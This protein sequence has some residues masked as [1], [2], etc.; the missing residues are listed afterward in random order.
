M[1]AGIRGR[2]TY[3]N[4]TAT[5]ALFIAL[6]AGAYA[7]GLARDSVRSK[8]IKDG[9]VKEADLG[10]DAVTATKL[11]DD[12]VGSPNVI[13]DALQGG[14]ISESSLFN[15]NSLDGADLDES[16]LF[17]DNS[18]Q[19][20]DIDETTLSGVNAAK[21]GGGDVCR[22][23]GTYTLTATDIENVC[24]AGP[25]TLEASCF[26]VGST[27]VASLDLLT[28][29]D[30]AYVGRSS[31]T[32]FTDPDFDTNESPA[33]TQVVDDVGG[34]GST[35]FAASFFAGL[36]GSGQLVG[37]AGVHATAT[38]PG[39]DTCHFNVVAFG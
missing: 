22:S 30:N 21:V 11:G 31:N 20:A 19:G 24:T 27:V 33:M 35:W 39:I 32:F 16:Q 28:S 10:D 23:N 15:D 4:V 36:S 29:A 7:A 37:T 9:Q 18:L 26:G 3:A 6:G 14:D 25:F 12:A 1:L 2:L 17:N 34:T 5:I 8:H 38:D 13:A